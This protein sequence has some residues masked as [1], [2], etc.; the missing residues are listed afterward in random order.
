MLLVCMPC[1]DAAACQIYDELLAGLP[2][3]N[4]TS[5]RSATSDAVPRPASGPLPWLYYLPGSPYLKAE[6]VDV[7]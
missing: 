1:R 4:G 7:E 2:G 3:S 5:R 6:D